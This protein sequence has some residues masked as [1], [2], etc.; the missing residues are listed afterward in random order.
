MLVIHSSPAA[1]LTEDSTK[2]FV[3]KVAR[4]YQDNEKHKL[5]FAINGYNV[6]WFKKFQK[7]KLIKDA[8]DK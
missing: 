4:H 3:Q 5:R 2:D 1:S 8:N 6:G 7:D